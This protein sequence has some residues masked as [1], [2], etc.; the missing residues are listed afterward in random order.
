MNWQDAEKNKDGSVE[1]PN[2][3]LFLHY[4]QALT[5]LFRIENSLRMFVYIVLKDK[6]KGE[7]PALTITSD[8]GSQTTISA[9]AKKRISQDETF[10]YLGYSVASP[11]MHLTSG[12]LI[13]IILADSYWPFFK[14]YF[15]AS[16]DLVRT[17][18]EEIGNVRNSLAHFRALKEDDVQVVKQNANQVLSRV[19]FALKGVIDC[20]IV[21]PT[22][23][24]ESWYKSLKTLGGQYLSLAFRQSE[25]EKGIRI[26]LILNCP[27][28]SQPYKSETHRSFKTVSLNVTAIL[29]ASPAILDNVIFVSDEVPYCFY[30]GEGDPDVSKVIHFTF[31]RQALREKFAELKEEF[32][33]A[34]SRIGDEIELIRDDNLAR[35]AFVRIARVTANKKSSEYWYVDTEQLDSSLTNDDPPEY[36]RGKP[37][38]G[39][40]FITDTN[41]FPWMPVDISK[42]N[43]PF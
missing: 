26:E 12:E 1:L 25:D 34:L 36:W 5:V 17:K 10:G 18:L 23:C 39:T 28:L 24:E 3:W 4:Y 35:G 42:G 32:E 11:L 33:S 43:L 9:I 13:R 37:D 21:V 7:W 27:F 40:D 29:L 41:S 14:E 15:P 16:K 38:R 8:D 22:N 30:K 31:S 6:R 19:E 2:N 20:S